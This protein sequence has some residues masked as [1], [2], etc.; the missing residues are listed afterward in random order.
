M[1]HTL[2]RREFVHAAARLSA[3][4]S[5]ANGERQRRTRV[6]R[7]LVLR[8]A[9]RAPQPCQLSPGAYAVSRHAAEFNTGDDC[10]AIDSGK[11]RD[12][13]LGPAQDH[14]IQHCIMN[15][16]HGGLTL[17]SLVGGGIRNVYAR[18]LTMRNS[19]WATGS[20]FQA[21]VV[22]GPVASD[23][24]GLAP[25]PPILPIENV[26]ITDCD[27]GSPTAAGPA[28]PTEPGPV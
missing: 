9:D 2:S 1:A 6:C 5:L 4:R 10:I 3:A 17:G 8:R 18:G 26:S 16:G 21:L 27:L 23:Y 7:N 28:G 12:V 11:N 20:C 25:V 24:N 19:N 13:G 15:S 14:V 22:Q